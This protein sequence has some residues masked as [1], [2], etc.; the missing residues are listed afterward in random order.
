MKRLWT[1]LLVA[2][3]AVSLA[4]NVWQC[5]GRGARD[6]TRADTVRVTYT[7]T[8]RYAAPVAR[9]S[10]V[11]RYVAVR[12]PVAR[13]TAGE[14][15]ADVGKKVDSVSVQLPIEQKRYEDST[16][17]AYVSGYAPRIDSIFVYPRR[18]VVTV[19]TVRTE[20]KNKRWGVGVQAGYGLTS[21]GA[22]PF[23]GIGVSYYLFSW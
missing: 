16:Y 20:W 17:T 14:H 23:V 6:G 15:L 21:K 7:D 10:V 2:G 5:R 4:V 9:E 13:D 11:V 22:Q 18:E 8:V 19:R 1:T 3:L 12:L